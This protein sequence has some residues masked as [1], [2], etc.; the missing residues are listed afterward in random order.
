MQGRKTGSALLLNDHPL[1]RT[2]TLT[3]LKPYKPESGVTCCSNESRAAQTGSGA[4]DKRE[5]RA[6]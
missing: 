1:S 6:E 5:S 2:L 3:T 4:A